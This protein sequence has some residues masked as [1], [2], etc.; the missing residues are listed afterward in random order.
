MVGAASGRECCQGGILK[1]RKSQEPSHL[2]ALPLRLDV[3]APFHFDLNLLNPGGAGSGCTGFLRALV[4]FAI[5]PL[6]VSASLLL[7]F[8]T[9]VSNVSIGSLSFSFHGLRI[10]VL[11]LR[12]GSMSTS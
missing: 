8:M 12:M 3:S 7:I 1:P 10:A 2:S 4:N 6:R 9:S 5:A 11:R